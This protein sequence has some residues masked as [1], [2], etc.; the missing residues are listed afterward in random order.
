MQ[1]HC[2]VCSQTDCSCEGADRRV[3]QTGCLSL[4]T[5]DDQKL[6]NIC[7]YI[8]IQS[9]ACIDTMIQI[10]P[11]FVIKKEDILLYEGP[12]NPDGT[13]KVGVT[14]DTEK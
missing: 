13:L 5:Q 10:K 3:G 4:R 12:R 6:E 11:T 9:D 7:A 8:D 1:T 14:N 2:P